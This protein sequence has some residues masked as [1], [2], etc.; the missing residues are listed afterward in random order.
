MPASSSLK[1]IHKRK[2]MNPVF[3]RLTYF[4]AL[5]A[6]YAFVSWYNEQKQFNARHRRTKLHEQNH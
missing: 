3:S 5:D 6:L 2:F 4:A 1:S